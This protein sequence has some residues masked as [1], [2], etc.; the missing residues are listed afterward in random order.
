L[1]RRLGWTGIAIGGSERILRRTR[2]AASW[3][4]LKVLAAAVI[5]AGA[6]LSISCTSTTVPRGGYAVRAVDD[7]RVLARGR[8][9][10]YGPGHCPAC[11]GDPVRQDEARLGLEVPLSGGRIFDLGLAGSIAA[12]N[13]TSDV[14]TGVGAVSDDALVRTLRYGISRHGRPLAPLMSFSDLTTADLQAVISFLRTLPPVE[15]PQ[16]RSGLNWLGAL[17]FETIMRPQGPSLAPR[18]Q[19][20]PS[21][22]AEYGRYLAYTVANC[23]GCHTLRSKL[24]GAYIGPA[25]AGGLV[26]REGAARFVTPNLTPGDRGVMAHLTE[27]KFIGLFRERMRWRSGSPMPWGPFSR[28]SDSDLGAIYRYLL[29]LPPTLTPGHATAT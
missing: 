28:M 29:T 21:R 18:Q 9:I 5:F 4:R 8:Y 7:P 20:Q 3:I 16:A 14:S 19:I 22:T 13:I 17:G 1:S 27:E 24:N 15:A 2:M 6:V 25:F 11:H 12:P 23:H 10:V 26:L